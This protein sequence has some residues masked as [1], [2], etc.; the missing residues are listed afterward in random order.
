MSVRLGRWAVFAAGACACVLAGPLREACAQE[1][2]SPAQ[3]RFASGRR[4]LDARNFPEALEDFRASLALF[5]SPNTR[6]YLARTLR[7][8]G[9]AGE[10][11]REFVRTADEAEARAGA[12][13]RYAPTGPVARAE[14]Q[15]LLPSIAT[16]TLVLDD[17]PPGTRVR[18]NGQPIE[19]S[20]WG[21]AVA[22]DPGSVAVDAE[23]PQRAAFHTV[24]ELAVGH[25][26]R[27]QV[28]LAPLLNMGDG[29]GAAGHANGGAG[30][31]NANGGA[32]S[33][34]NAA[35]GAGAA[36]G[37]GGAGVVIE[38][39]SGT[40][41]GPGTGIALM[42]VGGVLVLGGSISGGIAL[43]MYGE[44]ESECMAASAGG[45]CT[46]VPEGAQ[47]RASTGQALGT[48]FTLGLIFGSASLITG[49]VVYAVT[50]GGRARAT[51]AVRGPRLGF[52]VEPARDGGAFVVR[53]A[54]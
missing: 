20:E 14:A 32:N 16:L 38:S 43:S 49:G 51:S 7:E 31:V 39:A 50:G 35:G 44:L 2:G 18:L 9:R 45:P 3:V 29:F 41:P 8:A 25:A 28:R 48:T 19:R 12:E 54:F 21:V 4:H 17:V 26:A 37:T 53:G 30:F 47:G 10:A 42:V 5:P 13:P 6:L 23:A 36:G 1:Q 52:S 34:G 27:V 22:F 24:V 15:A 33:T 40:G 11:Y 46:V